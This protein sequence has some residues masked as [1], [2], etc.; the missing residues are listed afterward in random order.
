MKIATGCI[1]DTL[2]SRALGLARKQRYLAYN[3]TGYVLFCLY[4]KGKS[5]HYLSRRC[6]HVNNI[7]ICWIKDVNSE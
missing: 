6:V 4:H 7:E 3:A 2:S 5:E 1:Q